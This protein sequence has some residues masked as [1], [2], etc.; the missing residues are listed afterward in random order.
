MH[1]PFSGTESK[2]AVELQV[3]HVL[4][5]SHAWHPV[6]DYEHYLHV[7]LSLSKYFVYKHSHFPFNGL[8][9]KPF[10]LSQIVH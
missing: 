3:L 4:L 8:V 10:S 6:I 9:T 5:L 7:P 1:D 2:L